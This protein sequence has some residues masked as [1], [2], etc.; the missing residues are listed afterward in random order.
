MNRLFVFVISLIIIEFFGIMFFS[1][2]RSQGFLIGGYIPI[3][4]IT[5]CT[6]EDS[7]IHEFAHKSDESFG[8]ISSTLE[9]HNAVINFAKQHPEHFWSKAILSGKGL[10]NGWTEAYA[11][12][13]SSANGKEDQ[14]PVE[15]QQFYN[16]RIK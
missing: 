3:L 5:W 6:T 10:Q 14:I 13:F 12:M 7:C 11:Q 15:L 16:W 9:Y 2:N 1:F 4:N 8:F